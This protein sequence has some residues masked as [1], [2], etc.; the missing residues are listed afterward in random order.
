MASIMRRE[1]DLALREAA[2]Q[3]GVD[4]EALAK[5]WGE[6]PEKER[7]AQALHF[8]ARD[9][10]TEA[11]LKKQ[12]EQI[13]ALTAGTNHP[14]RAPAPSGGAAPTNEDQFVLAYADGG[15]D[16]HKAA[17]ALAK[18]IGVSI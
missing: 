9:M 4:K 2:I 6:L 8:I 11:R 1:N 16:D 10:L 17:R 3:H 13:A 14:S 12:D 18:R 15:S 5:R 7:S